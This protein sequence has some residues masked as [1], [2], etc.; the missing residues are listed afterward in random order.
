V[1]II[2]NIGYSIITT[3][4]AISPILPIILI[5]VLSFIITLIYGA[6][7]LYQSIKSDNKHQ[8]LPGIKQAKDEVLRLEQQTSELEKQ[9]T[10]LEKKQEML[11]WQIEAM[12]LT[13]Q[14]PRLAVVIAYQGVEAE[15]Q[16]MTNLRYPKDLSEE[17]D[18]Q[19]PRVF[20]N[21]N[22]L[23]EAIGSE[24]AETL[25]QMHD[26]RNR[27]VHGEVDAEEVSQDKATEY[28][29]QAISLAG[30]ISSFG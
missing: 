6:I 23:E 15:L 5:I 10:E 21:I 22:L 8:L 13:K 17:L 1:L 29:K 9:R 18:E 19:E 7:M 27:I 28:V 4:F 2:T 20:H 11:I 24:S 25:K 30:I 14:D 12:A 16:H 3:L 26:L